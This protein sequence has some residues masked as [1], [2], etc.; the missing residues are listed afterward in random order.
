[1]KTDITAKKVKKYFEKGG[2]EIIKVD[3]NDD[4]SLRVNFDNG[5]VRIYDMSYNLYGVFEVLKDKNKFKEVFIDE[6]GNIAWERDKNI[7]SQKEWN[8]KIDICKDSV[9]LDSK[10]VK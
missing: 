10:P 1:M 6:F 4:Y 2:R 3:P 5:E 7:D 8:N 9:Y